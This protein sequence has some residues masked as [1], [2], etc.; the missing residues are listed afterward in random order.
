MMT[1]FYRIED[2]TLSAR[3]MPWIA[4][5]TDGVVH[6]EECPVC[7]G[8]P[9]VPVGDFRALLESKRG[10]QWPDLIGCGARVGLFVVSG[11]FVKALRGKGVRVELG[12]RVEFEEPGPKR[13]T[14]ADAPEYHWVDGERHR[15][16][17]MD[18]EASGYVGVEYC[19]NCGGRSYDIKASKPRD[20]P[21]VFDYDATSGLDLFTTDMSSRAFYCTER[22]LECA[23]EHRLTNVAFGPVEEGPFAKPVRY[24]Q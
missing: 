3:G 5:F 2:R 16:A 12:G 14:L 22:V 6:T 20:F 21:V 13:L 11:R 10:T 1:R 19:A 9:L 23:R 4:K 18:F 8:G 17:K 24:W 7:G 15:A